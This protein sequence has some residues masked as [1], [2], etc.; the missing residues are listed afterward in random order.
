MTKPFALIIEDDPKLG[1]IYTIALQ[2]I[3]FD[4]DLDTFGNQ[5]LEKLSK[6]DPAIILLDLHMPYASGVD[7]LRQIRSDSRWA[8]IPVVI[9]TADIY[10]AKTINE[11]PECILIKPVSVSHIQKI[12]TQLVAV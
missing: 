5:F 2:Q 7:I 8:N 4:V 3:G 6:A 10:L 1:P 9:M 11:P 12:V